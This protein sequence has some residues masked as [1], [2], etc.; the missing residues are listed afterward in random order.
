[1]YCF[2]IL[3]ICTSKINCLTKIKKTKWHVLQMCY[4]TATNDEIDDFFIFVAHLK[5]VGKKVRY[6]VYRPWAR[7]LRH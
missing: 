3:K 5:M 4:K 1:M 2:T 7:L 6:E